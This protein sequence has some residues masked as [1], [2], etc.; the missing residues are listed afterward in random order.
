[1]NQENVND[2]SESI[3]EIAKKFEVELSKS[4][5]FS[6]Y[7]KINSDGPVL[8]LSEFQHT[9]G[10]LI[11]FYHYQVITLKPHINTSSSDIIII[12]S[13]DCL[14]YYQ[15]LYISKK[16]IK[17]LSRSYEKNTTEFKSFLDFLESLQKK[18]IKF[19]I[20]VNS[21]K[22]LD[23]FT[24]VPVKAK[25]LES[26][27]RAIKLKA[28]QKNELDPNNKKLFQ[29]LMISLSPF[30]L[31]TLNLHYHCFQ[32]IFNAAVSQEDFVFHNEIDSFSNSFDKIDPYGFIE[33]M[34]ETC[35]R[36]AW[37][38]QLSNIRNSN[39]VIIFILLHRYIFDQI[40]P[41]NHYFFKSD[42]ANVDIIFPIAKYT[43]QKINLSLD[44][45]P[46]NTKPR[47]TIRKILREDDFYKLAI[48][49]LEQMQFYTS[50]FDICACALYTIQSIKKGAEHYSKSS[51]DLNS[52]DL[53]TIFMGVAIASDI[54]E[55][56]NLSNFVNVFVN[57]SKSVEL[58]PVSNEMN[59]AK[60]VLVIATKQLYEL[61]E[62]ERKRFQST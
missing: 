54:P 38:F 16:V 20:S 32:D 23:D 12:V 11:N 5:Q 10:E 49:N 44:F 37:H 13:K 15:L 45:F 42:Y 43:F 8:N 27:S 60:N 52:N 35:E 34:I 62:K 31:K 14:I 9:T 33:T 2:S 3:S 58:I 59:H 55:L 21:K 48:D 26:F 56:M 4:P 22:I 40:Y 25:C 6:S 41:S 1:M 50:P 51:L 28:H 17:M 39:I 36:F 53:I 18:Y 30:L 61:S 29:K 19:P 57:N 46:P 24:N 47:N 7:I